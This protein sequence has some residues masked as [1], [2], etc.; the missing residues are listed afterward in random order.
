MDENRAKVI[1]D[2]P[3]FDEKGHFLPGNQFGKLG[4]GIPRPNAR[5]VQYKLFCP[6]NLG[7]LLVY[8]NLDIHA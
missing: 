4:R 6:S 8:T 1:K 3:K 7:Y 5:K 2:A